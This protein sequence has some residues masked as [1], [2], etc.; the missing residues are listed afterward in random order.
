MIAGLD[1]RRRSAGGLGQS[2]PDLQNE[3]EKQLRFETLLTHIV[4]RFVSL[5]PE[6]LDEAI[7]DAQSQCC[8]VLGLDRSA[9][10]QVVSE[11]PELVLVTHLYQARGDPRLIHPEDVAV[12]PG[13]VRLVR[14]KEGQP[15]HKRISVREHWPWGYSQLRQGKT[16]AISR[17][18]DLPAEASL[19]KETFRLYGTASTVVVPLSAGGRW[20]GI[21]SF[22]SLREERE[23][24]RDLVK[25]LELIAQ[26]FASAIAQSK[27]EGRI[28]ELRAELNHAS[29]VS[30][31]GELT[32]T[33]A[34]EVNRPLAAILS[35]AQA[36]RHWL[37]EGEPERSELLA[38]LDDIIADD[39]RAGQ[40]IHRIRAMLQRDGHA[41]ESVDLNQ[42]A[43][44]VAELLSG[45]LRGADVSV[46]LDFAPDLPQV[47]ANPVEVQQVL[48]NLMVNAIQSM[49][50]PDV[51]DRSL[52]VAT[53]CGPRQA[54]VEVCDTGPGLSEEAPERLWEPFYTTKPGHL[55][56]GLPICRR[57]AEAHG[58]RIE[59]RNTP[60]G[61]AVF[62]FALP[63]GE[64]P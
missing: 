39:K 58:G 42:L 45:E 37:A 35:N 54:I 57:I 25:R 38:V 16:L 32:A 53:S 19:D 31:L 10:W 1:G 26:V 43:L 46:R 18:S 44:G 7:E 9:L 4:A 47:R 8:Q 61:G 14:G 49:R 30:L 22:A 56:M 60:E 36:A 24:P 48:L 40:V 59:V 21:L 62:R 11:D 3:L 29:R 13:R 5:P 15:D 41:R 63:V 64:E 17:M 34:H 20:L 50:A 6:R 2:K 33:L 12:P 23:W 27:A 51:P 52:R 28:A 55:G